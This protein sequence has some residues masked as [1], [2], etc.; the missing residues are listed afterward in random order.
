MAVRDALISF[1]AATAQAQAEATK[2]AQKAGIAFAKSKDDRQRYKGRKPSY[3]RLQ[4]E[5]V[6]SMLSQGSNGITAIA[7]TVG[8]SPQTVYRIQSNPAAAEAA[9][10]CWGM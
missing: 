7:R 9:L 4:M 1:M 8:V 5:M 3:S 10:A 6:Q 2:E